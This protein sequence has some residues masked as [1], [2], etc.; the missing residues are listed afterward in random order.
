PPPL[1][2]SVPKMRIY[3]VKL[4]IVLK[5]NN[6]TTIRILRQVIRD[7][8]KPYL[9]QNQVSINRVNPID[10]GISTLTL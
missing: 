7:S 6:L 1:R 3:N 5:M 4:F 8:R 10:T 9:K 2:G